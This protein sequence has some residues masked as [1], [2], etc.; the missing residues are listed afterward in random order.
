MNLELIN[1]KCGFIIYVFAFVQG[2][3][4]ELNLQVGAKVT[5]TINDEFKEKCDENIIWVDYKNI[6][7]VVSIGSKIFLDDGLIALIVVEKCELL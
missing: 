7:H 3:N 4:E 1:L 6:V 2:V 5:V